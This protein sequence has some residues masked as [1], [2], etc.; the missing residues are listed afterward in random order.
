MTRKLGQGLPNIISREQVEIKKNII[1]KFLD[2]QETAYEAIQAS[3][4]T[5][6]CETD[7]L[8]SYDL[9]IY[10][11]KEIKNEHLP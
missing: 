10:D 6:F 2:Q 11:N 8:A 5:T 3:S 9:T 7:P 4:S 1:W